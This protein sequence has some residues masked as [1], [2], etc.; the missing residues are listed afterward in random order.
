MTGPLFSPIPE[1][2]EISAEMDAAYDSA[3]SA[4]YATALA[5][6]GGVERRDPARV[7]RGAEGLPLPGE[8]GFATPDVCETLMDRSF[9]LRLSDPAAMLR[10]AEMAAQSAEELDTEVYGAKSVADLQAR[11]WAEMAN[12][13]RVIGD[14]PQAD[15]MM[16]RAVDC[17][18]R[19]TGDPRLLARL[20]DLGAALACAQRRFDQAFRLLDIGY[21]IY[22]KLGDRHSAGRVLIGRGL[23]AGYTGDPLEG[24]RYLVHGLNTIDRAREPQLA[25]QALHNILL[26]RVELGEYEEARRTLQ[27]M[28]PLYARFSDQLVNIKLLWVEGKIAAGLGELEEA[29][30]AFA[31]SRDRFDQIGLGYRAAL[32]S[33]DLVSVWLQQGRT[34][35]I[36]QLVGELLVTFRAVGVEREALAGILLLRDAVECEQATLELLQLIA[37][38]LGKLDGRSAPPLDPEIR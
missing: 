2:V 25:F 4:A 24:I 32:V 28:R 19:G 1:E 22:I 23:Y 11:A 38:S 33:L 17:R 26:L 31:E 9:D 7:V 8:A 14:L 16:T 18:S 36:R 12:A 13:H 21:S 3:I 20:S 34:G 30:A 29:E 15:R 10:L 37:H 35:E 6:T 27:H 5:K